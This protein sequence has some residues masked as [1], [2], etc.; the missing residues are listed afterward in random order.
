MRASGSEHKWISVCALCG[1]KKKGD[2]K[3]FV[4]HIFFV[5]PP[6]AVKSEIFFF[7]CESQNDVKKQKVKTSSRFCYRR[8]LYQLT[9][10]R[11]T[12]HVV[13]VKKKKPRGPHCWFMCTRAHGQK[14]ASCTRNNCPNTRH[15][16][17]ELIE[18]AADLRIICWHGPGTSLCARLFVFLLRTCLKFERDVH[19]CILFE[20]K[21]CLVWVFF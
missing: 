15:G 6:P 10:L 3:Y 7:F 8:S 18:L 11:K 2:A 5:P 21:N 12:T 13:E 19:G 1:V 9:S 14:A 17:W 16:W 4:K 20:I